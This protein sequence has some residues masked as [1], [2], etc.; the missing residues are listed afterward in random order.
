MTT[1]NNIESIYV[2][3]NSIRLRLEQLSLRTDLPEDFFDEMYSILSRLEQG[4]NI[5]SNKY[6]GE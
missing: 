6:K 3:I 2:N 4:N 1:R 5:I